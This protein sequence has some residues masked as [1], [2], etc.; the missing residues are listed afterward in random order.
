MRLV[1][2]RGPNRAIQ[3]NPAAR[4][5]LWFS[6]KEPDFLLRPPPEDALQE[7]IVSPPVNRS[8]VRDIDPAMIEPAAIA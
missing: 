1:A 8:G 6:A 3:N 4:R 5:S 2:A 7:W